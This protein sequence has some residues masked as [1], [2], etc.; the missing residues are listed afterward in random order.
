MFCFSLLGV[1]L[2]SHFWLVWFIIR[3]LFFQFYQPILAGTGIVIR[4]HRG[5]GSAKQGLG[6]KHLC[7]HD[8]HPAG[9]L[10]G[11]GFLLLVTGLLLLITHHQS[12][13]GERKKHG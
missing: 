13:T 10:A 9:M 11:R 5:G 7:Q 3:E 12:Q 1:V 2:I 6:L 4:L 8:G